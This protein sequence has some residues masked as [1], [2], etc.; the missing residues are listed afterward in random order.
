MKKAPSI[1][2]LNGPNLNMLGVR[3]PKIYGKAT[4][5]DVEAL[6]HKTAH[7]LELTVECFQSNLEGEL[8][9]RIQKSRLKNKGI[10]INAGGYSHTSVALFDAL[11]LSELPVIEVHITNIYARE[12]F[13][14]H[15]LLSR[16]A[17]GVI[18]GL[19]INGYA[20]ALRAMA[21]FLSKPPKR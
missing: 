20:L 18:C 3:E 8:V 16:A 6:C 5:K 14:H 4:L 15:S 13:R 9:E 7:D 10:V 21:E 17:K 1:L 12:P 11:S 19:G 2:I